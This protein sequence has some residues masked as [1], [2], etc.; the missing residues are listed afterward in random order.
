MIVTRSGPHGLGMGGEERYW[1]YRIVL[2][3]A[4]RSS[5]LRALTRS[6]FRLDDPEPT[7]WLEDDH[8][9]NRQEAE[10]PLRVETVAEIRAFL[11]GKHPKAPVFPIMPIVTDGTHILRGDLAEAG[12][13][14][15][16]DSGRVQ[17]HSFR[18][19]CLT[20]LAAA[21]VPL[22]TLQTFARHST[23]VLT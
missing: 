17:F 18:V 21:G 7:M 10:L 5:E 19:T 22:K 3:T 12:I 1:L 20:W 9:K 4:L 23:P 13:E 11:E 15:E 14:Y 8:T 2:E 6:S 16:T